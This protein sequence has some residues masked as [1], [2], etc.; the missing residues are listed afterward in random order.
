MKKY[1]IN[2]NLIQVIKNLYDKA[3]SAV[4][5]NGS[6]GDWLQTIV[7]SLT[8]MSTLTHPL[9][10]ISGRDHNR[11]VRIG[12]RT[13]TNPCF[14][15]GLAGE[16][17]ELAKLAERLDKASTAYGMETSAEKTKLMRT[18]LVA[19]KRRSK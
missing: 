13:I 9:Q 16:E 10:H 3:T 19:S 4:L 5:F 8:G 2:A 6:I 1:D 11:H 15:D 14:A 18:T 17:E 12:G 7:A